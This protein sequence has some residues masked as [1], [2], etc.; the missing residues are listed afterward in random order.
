MGKLISFPQNKHF[1]DEM[2]TEIFSSTEEAV[3]E[4]LTKIKS[5]DF[6]GAAVPLSWMLAIGVPTAN[7]YSHYFSD[8]ISKNA[9]NED[10]LKK[11]IEFLDSGK[12]NDFIEL[13][14]LCF[15]VGGI[16]AINCY[17]Q[18]KKNKTNVT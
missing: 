1:H 8:S 3:K 16:E 14:D 17:I 15:G 7:K 4:F 5:K 11:L 2:T 13:M 9:S 12:T 18:I 6:Y 10:N